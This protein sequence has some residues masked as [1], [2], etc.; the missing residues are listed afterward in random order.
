MME[1]LISPAGFH[2]RNRS[3][4][5]RDQLGKSGS[6][7]WQ[8]LGLAAVMLLLT[9]IAFHFSGSGG[10]NAATGNPGQ[11][12]ATSNKPPVPAENSGSR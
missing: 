1:P 8:V 6:R 9:G 2:F 11:S 4:T 12:I 5:M 10:Q 7:K 3:V